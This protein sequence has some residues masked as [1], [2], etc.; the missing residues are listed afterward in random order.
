MGTR[1]RPRVS[2]QSLPIKEKETNIDNKNKQQSLSAN[3]CKLLARAF[4]MRL[5][6]GD[7]SIEASEQDIDGG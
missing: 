5:W 3:K 7:V 6:V 4:W 1:N 2:A